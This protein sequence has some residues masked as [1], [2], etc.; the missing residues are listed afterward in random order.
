MGVVLCATS[1]MPIQV[2]FADEDVFRAR[3]AVARTSDSITFDNSAPAGY[4]SKVAHSLFLMTGIGLTGLF[5]TERGHGYIDFVSQRSGNATHDL[6]SDVTA[7]PQSY[8][9]EESTLTLG[10]TGTPRE[11]VAVS[12][13]IG[14]KTGTSTLGAA[15]GALGSYTFQKDRFST[16]GA[17]IGI[18]MAFPAMG[19]YFGLN[20]AIAFMRGEWSDDH[21]PT[22][23][24][25]ESKH[26]AGSGLGA[27]YSYLFSKNVGMSAE[28]KSN[29][30]TYEFT[31]P[32]RYT[33]EE[34]VS[35][36]GLSLF[37]QF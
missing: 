20:A 15:P 2:A 10:I 27:S 21:S 4:K 34:V 18:G 29:A 35:S 28:L 11:R 19:G 6:W 16:S 7:A 12:S 1:S 14:Y 22:S 37:A 3:L 33:V 30:Y 9:R 17:I 24:K 32:S 31:S 8:E 25:A 5:K 26:T 13:F 36:F 23:Y